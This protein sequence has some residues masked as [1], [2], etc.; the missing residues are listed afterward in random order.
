MDIYIDG[1]LVTSWTS[2]G[3]T[4][5]FETVDLDITGQSVELRGVL[6]D[7]EWLSLMEVWY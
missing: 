2:S 4:L 3:A 6:S 5:G 7:A 1:V